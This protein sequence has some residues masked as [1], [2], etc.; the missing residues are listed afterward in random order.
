MF[1]DTAEATQKIRSTR[2]KCLLGLIIMIV[3]R[4]YICQ[5]VRY[6]SYF[7]HIREKKRRGKIEMERDQI[8]KGSRNE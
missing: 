1:K 5:G 4:Y 2:G 7:M 8:S 6:C 3:L